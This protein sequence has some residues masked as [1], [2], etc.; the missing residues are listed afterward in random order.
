MINAAGEFI[1]CQKKGL[2]KEDGTLTE[3][4]MT[5]LDDFDML[6]VKNK[7]K[8]ASEILGEDSL[9]LIH[10]YRELFPAERLPSKKLARQS[11]KELKDKLVWFFKTYPEYNWNVVLDATAAYVEYYSKQLPL[12]YMYMQ[13]SSYFIKKKDSDG[14]FVS[15]LADACQQ[16]VDNPDQVRRELDCL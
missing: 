16:L 3:K 8:V 4:A 14:T 2:I 7:K 5:I 15:A 12:P 6:I 11:V 9:S 10:K 13:T 1:V